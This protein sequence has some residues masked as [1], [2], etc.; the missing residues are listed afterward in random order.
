MMLNK[1][2][3][4][5]QTLL[6]LV[7]PCTKAELLL[8]LF[9]FLGYG[10]LGFYVSK[11]YFIIFDDRIPWDAYFSF[12]N[13]SIVRNG[14]GFER[15]PLANYFFDAIRNFA[16]Y[17]SGSKVNFT[18]RMVLALISNLVVSLSLVQIF[19][20]LKNIIQLPTAVSL[21]LVAFFS[22][23]ST[24]I[25]LSFTPETYTYTLFFL[26]IF[27]YYAARNLMQEKNINGIA[28]TISGVFIGGLTIT[29][30]VKVYI[31]IL[32]EKK[33][34]WNWK[35]LSHAAARVLISLAVFIL[36]YLNRLQFDISRILNKTTEQY[37]KFTQAKA[38]PVWDMIISWFWG[39][40]FL[41][42]GFT[43]LDYHNKK[44]F[45][46]KALFMDVYNTPASYVFVAGTFG[47]I[48]WSYFK[49]FRNKLVQILMI[50]FF[51]DI[52]IHCIL[53]FGLKTGYIYGG[54]Y[55]Y[56]IPLMLG[57]LFHAYRCSPK[58]LSLL[59]VVLLLLMSYLFMNNFY[60]MR[61]FFLFL[62][63]FYQV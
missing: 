59:M 30:I 44:G 9:Y 61:E 8:F 57:W 23:F 46:Y 34:F 45:E 49:N 24:T 16:F 14:G 1:P 7:F 55:I 60:R 28:L 15:H 25:L 2:K 37:E 27:N 6:K 4:K 32:F 21:L 36:L 50:S 43:M 11:D 19:K 62:E 3:S 22:I 33:I 17:F 47:L 40:T 20:Y 41:F 12:D 51:V 26:L 31:P 29:N 58:V 53:Q 38:V 42:P 5:L 48:L 35:S 10:I 52:I 13:R 18:F 39:G 56:I 54:H 63:R